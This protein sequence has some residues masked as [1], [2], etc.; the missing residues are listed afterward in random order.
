MFIG[1]FLVY[2]MRLNFSVAIL[3]MTNSINATGD[4]IT[5]ISSDN[6]RPDKHIAQGGHSLSRKLREL[7]GDFHWDQNQQ[8]TVLYAFFLGYLITQIPGG[9]FAEVAS[10]TWVFGLGVGLTS[11]LTCLTHVTA[12]FNYYALVALRVCEGLSEGITFPAV[13]AFIARWSPANEQNSALNFVNAGTVV[14]TVVT[15]P[16]S[17]YL[18]TSPMGWSVSFYLFGLLGILWTV[19]WFCVAADG[20]ERHPWIS[21][22][23]RKYIVESRSSKFKKARP[24]IPW[25]Q[26]LFSPA[27]LILG[28]AKLAASFNYYMMLIELPTYLNDMFAIDITANGWINGGMNLCIAITLLVTARIADKLIERK[29]FN[30]TRLRKF[31]I[32][33][34]QLLPSFCMVLLSRIGCDYD[35]VMVTLFVNYLFLGFAGGGDGG[36]AFDIAPRFAGA[37]TGVLNVMANVAGLLAPKLVGYLTEDN[38]TLTQWHLAFLYTGIFTMINSTLFLMFG[39]AEEQ[40]WAQEERSEENC[41]AEGNSLYGRLRKGSDIANQNS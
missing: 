16:V 12:Y 19:F 18:C 28:L 41:D 39:T 6:C 35:L 11:L 27:V 20:P 30:K 29:A 2:A 15:L 31:F 37:V 36:M 14:G 33:C 23:E 3:A 25:R 22:E 13:F 7:Q 4:N 1:A 21:A 5:F 10:A 8:A 34:S 17:A 38:N 32:V 9:Y 40:I 24:P 26:I